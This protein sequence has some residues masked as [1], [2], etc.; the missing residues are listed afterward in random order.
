MTIRSDPFGF[1]TLVLMMTIIVYATRIGGFWLIGRVT[2]GPRLQRMLEA[3]PGAVIA[4]TVAPI[5]LTGGVTAW[6]AVI[7]AG[8]TMIVVRNDFAAVV[9]GVAVAALVRAAGL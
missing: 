2:I 9:A 1:F 7:A 6:L 8:A 3:L 4:A 5:L